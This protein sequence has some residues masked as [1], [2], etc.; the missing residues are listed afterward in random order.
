VLWDGYFPLPP[1]YLELWHR[2]GTFSLCIVGKDPYPTN[3]VGIP[4]CKETWK[5]LDYRTSGTYVLRSLGMY[6]K[7][8]APRDAFMQLAQEGVGFLNATYWFLGRSFAKRH[9]QSLVAADLAVNLPLMAKSTKVLLCGEAGKLEWLL[10]GAALD[11]SMLGQLEAVLARA[12]KVPH[13]D[14]RNRYHRHR[15]GQWSAYWDDN[16]LTNY[17]D[18]SC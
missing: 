4:F 5:E 7:T 3:P 8:P 6:R 9:H 1:D 15:A 13:P 16:A 10:S 12:A 14:V 2:R 18:G 11:Q 17:R